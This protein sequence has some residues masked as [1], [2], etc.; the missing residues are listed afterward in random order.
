VGSEATERKEELGPA[1]DGAAERRPA[2]SPTSEV[3]EDESAAE[4]EGQD[5]PEDEDEPED[6]PREDQRPRA[7]A[8]RDE[9]LALAQRTQADFDNYRK[10]AAKE[11]AVAGARGKAALAREVL[12]VV[13]NLE[14]ALGS[15]GEAEAS[16]AEGVRLVH[17]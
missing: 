14:R 3:L 12:P 15:A 2:D 6:I 10:R 7:E 9:Y 1:S 13:D 5:E 16:L 11:I 8:E 4:A 17:A